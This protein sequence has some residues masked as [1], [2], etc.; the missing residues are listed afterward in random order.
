MGSRERRRENL[1]IGNFLICWS[2]AYSMLSYCCSLRSY[3]HE[4]DIFDINLILLLLSACFMLV[5]LESLCMLLFDLS[6]KMNL[7]CFFAFRFKNKKVYSV[8]T[9]R[10]L[11]STSSKEEHCTSQTLK[12]ATIMMA[13]SS[14]A[15][16]LCWLP[17]QLYF[18]GAQ[19][20]YFALKA[21]IPVRI[22]GVLVFMNSF[23][24]PIIY[25]FMNRTFREGYRKLLLDLLPWKRS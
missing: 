20:G 22:V 6:Y 8:S 25:G 4:V 1:G 11:N 21:S 19:L 24:N 2:N 16:I 13:I 10:P 3:L 12:R 7:K 9:R 18:F 14:L 17:N 5:S 23:M 15:L